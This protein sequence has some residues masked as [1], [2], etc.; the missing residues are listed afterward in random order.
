[1]LSVSDIC[2]VSQPRRSRMENE[3]DYWHGALA[4]GEK[5][6]TDRTHVP[7]S[8]PQSGFYRTHTGKPV[9]IWHDNDGCNFQIDGREVDS[10][11]HED[12]WGWVSRNPVTEEAYNFRRRLGFWPDVDPAIGETMGNNIAGATDPETLAGLLKVLETSA[13]QYVRVTDDEM[14]KRALSLRNRMQTLRLRADKLREEEKAPHLKAGQEVDKKWQPM[15]KAAQLVTAALN[16][17]MGQ[18]EDAKRADARRREWEAAE[19]AR[20]AADAAKAGEPVP[21]P[22]APPA[23]LEEPKD[24]IRSGYGKA[25]SVRVKDIVVGIRDF[26]ALLAAFRD[27]PVLREFLLGLAQKNIDAGIPVPGVI[28]EERSVVR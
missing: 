22:Q 3:Y 14:S 7:P 26:D 1:M 12:E 17:A 25:A 8:D 21:E 9:A 11:R 18:W 27:S 4:L 13:E 16:R 10:S 5:I 28:V 15:I 2:M 6:K 19:A 20:K 24:Q 23:G